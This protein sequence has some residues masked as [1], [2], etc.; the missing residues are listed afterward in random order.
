MDIIIYNH[1]E[2]EYFVKIVEDNKEDYITVLQRLCKGRIFKQNELFLYACVYKNLEVVKQIYKNF[3]FDILLCFRL[4]CEF[5]NVE[6]VKYLIPDLN[7][8]NLFINR[9]FEECLKTGFHFACISKKF[10]IAKYILETYKLGLHD[11]D[12]YKLVTLPADFEFIQ[13]ILKY[14]VGGS[15]QVEIDMSDHICKK[16]DIDL[17]NL[18]TSYNL[19]DFYKCLINMSCIRAINEEQF[20]KQRHIIDVSLNYDN[21]IINDVIR[22]MHDYRNTRFI[23]YLIEKGANHYNYIT[24]QLCRYDGDAELLKYVF[25]K[26]A[27]NY[28]R[29][30]L[31]AA[32]YMTNNDMLLFLINNSTDNFHECAL[33][34]C[35]NKTY[36]PN[37]ILIALLEKGA[38]DV[39]E[40]LYVVISG[41]SSPNIEFIKILH[42]YGATRF[43]GIT[44][45]QI[46]QLLNLGCDIDTKYANYMKLKRTNAQKYI[47]HI[48]N[49]FNI[50]NYDINITNLIV[51]Y[52]NYSAKYAKSK[53]RLKY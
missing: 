40:Y 26:G 41:R 34:V 47:K 23:K 25:E 32:Q 52:V 18:L 27:N 42:Q 5:S 53:L 35:K 1:D 10:D 50:P 37:N 36:R 45:P 8:Q 24:I 16:L 11:L 30:M 2:Y 51:E 22:N 19:I 6:I 20:I 14:Y 48:I 43:L 4:A 29:C 17:F 9:I 7:K 13:T 49:N 39:D 12:I 38:S 28:N 21:T 31:V 44:K 15:S 3:S 33:E 46:L